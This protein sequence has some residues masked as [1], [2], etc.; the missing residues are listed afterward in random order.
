MCGHNCFMIQH[1]LKERKIE[2]IGESC[3]FALIPSVYLWTLHFNY[4]VVSSNR[5]WKSKVIFT[6]N[7]LNG[8]T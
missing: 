2:I 1:I 6:P 8:L 7:L 3:T 4:E 5:K